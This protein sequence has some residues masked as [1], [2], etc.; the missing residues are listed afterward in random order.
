MWDYVNSA[1]QTVL[2]WGG[3][4]DKG[5]WLMVLVGVVIVGAVCLR[6]FGSRSSY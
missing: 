3:T 6:G 4:L 1:V 5:Q 2:G